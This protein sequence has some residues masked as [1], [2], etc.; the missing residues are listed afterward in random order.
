MIALNE[1]DLIGECLR[2]V[3]GLVDEIVLGPDTGTTGRTA[4]I[5]CV[6]RGRVSARSSSR[7]SEIERAGCAKRRLVQCGEN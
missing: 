2:S 4:S 3:R 5:A 1:E 7:L 6:D